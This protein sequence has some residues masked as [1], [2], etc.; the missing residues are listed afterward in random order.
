MRVGIRRAPI[1]YR[2]WLLLLS[3]D[4]SSVST[5]S[6][7]F[8]RILQSFFSFSLSSRFCYFVITYLGPDSLNTLGWFSNDFFSFIL[9]IFGIK[10]CKSTSY[11]IMI[12]LFFS[13]CNSFI[14]LPI[15]IFI[16]FSSYFIYFYYIFFYLQMRYIHE[17]QA[18]LK[19]FL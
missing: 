3:P 5:A 18:L 15:Q 1:E 10:F 14:V 12:S 13:Y 8:R 17:I 19:D 9:I 2:W 7:L 4:T 6:G 16:L 11:L